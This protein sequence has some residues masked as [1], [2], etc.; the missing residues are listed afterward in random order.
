MKILVAGGAGY[1]GSVLV[2]QLVDRGYEVDVVDLLWFGNY[3]PQE[4]RVIP[5]DIMSLKEDDLIGYDQVI[6]IAGLSNDPMAEYSPVRNFI[7]NAASPAYLCYISRRAGVKR[8]IYGS[9][10]SVYGYSADDLCDE[11]A[12]AT[13]DYPYGISKLQGEFACLN[14]KTSN[15]STIALRKGTVS[16]YSPRMRLDLIVNTMFKSALTEQTITVNNPSI[17]RPVLDIRDAASAYIRAV[18]ADYSISGI[19]NIAFANFTVGE[20]ADYVREV[21]KDYLGINVK[22]DIKNQQDYRNYKV[23]TEKARNM[24][25]FIGRYNITDIVKSLVDNLE[26]FKDMENDKYY[27]IK[28]FRNIPE[29]LTS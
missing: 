29:N 5:R 2:P 22:L 23:N 24:L 21:V 26:N 9:S 28:V 1:I 7:S 8:L 14:L 16:G 10:C 3:L 12:P 18:E 13:S 15:F 25:S 19:F 4:V 17:W 11:N 6:F 20:V 27:N